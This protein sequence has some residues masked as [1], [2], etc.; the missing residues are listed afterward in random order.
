M[1]GVQE[2]SEAMG[3]GFIV[4]LQLIVPY[5]REMILRKE[6]SSQQ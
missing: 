4:H 5:H 3:S 2:N 1:D 6:T